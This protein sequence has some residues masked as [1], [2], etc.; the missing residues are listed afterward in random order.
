[1]LEKME[2]KDNNFLKKELVDHEDIKEEQS[3]SFLDFVPLEEK[4][5][6][7]DRIKS[8]VR[9][10]L[11]GIVEKLQDQIQS[12]LEL[13]AVLY[14]DRLRHS[15]ETHNQVAGEVSNFLR[16]VSERQGLSLGPIQLQETVTLLERAMTT[17]R[18]K[19]IY[20]GGLKKKI[21]NEGNKIKNNSNLSNEEYLT[22]L[23]PS[24]GNFYQK[25]R[26]DHL[27]FFLSNKD[28][29]NEK[30]TEL[31]E[32]YHAGDE[33]LLKARM[34]SFHF[35]KDSTENLS[36]ELESYLKKAHEFSVQKGYMMTERPD[37]KTL[38]E[39][40]SF[41]NLEEF[42][43]GYSLFGMPDYLLRKLIHRELVNAKLL[44]KKQP[45]FSLNEDDLLQLAKKLTQK[46]EE[47]FQMHI[48][49]VQQHWDSCGAASVLGL[50][51]LK[52]VKS[53]K[54]TEK[55]IWSRI[56]QPYNYPPGMAIELIKAGFNVVFH[57]YPARVFSDHHPV[58]HSN[59][60]QLI[61]AC[62]LYLEMIDNA[63]KIGMDLIIAPVSSHEIK[64]E[65]KRGNVCLVSIR[66]RETEPG[67][68][69]AITIYGYHENSFLVNDPLGTI[70]QM[71]VEMIDKLVTT[72]MGQRMLVVKFH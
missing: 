34:K 18:E 66:L 67:P 69:H 68:L 3:C 14:L 11:Q 65:L 55:E 13:P 47:H 31:L 52:G 17:D 16:C 36:N 7:Q 27:K 4:L 49:N 48:P 10:Y 21:E 24:R 30:G 1:M 22:L 12:A 63:I 42:Q 44:D 9:P 39:L 60:P 35:E 26:Y 61:D 6:F 57:Q 53:K 43:W 19:N 33:R 64:E 58:F 54:E 2:N 40:L 8:E 70:N 37:I 51:T 20:S 62:K 32:K 15:W 25:Y 72:S 56:G 41:D 5:N 71:T 29:G 38:D 59:D 50:L 28:T 23:T 46:R 45:L